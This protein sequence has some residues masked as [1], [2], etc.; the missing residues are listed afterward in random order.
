MAAV[1]IR[2]VPLVRHMTRNPVILQRLRVPGLLTEEDRPG[3]QRHDQNAQTA[4][5][6]ER[7]Q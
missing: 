2:A 7:V 5:R 6:R 1:Q 3:I 4:L